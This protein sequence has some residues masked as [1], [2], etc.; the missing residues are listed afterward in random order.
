MR[1]VQTSVEEAQDALLAERAALKAL[2]DTLD[3]APKSEPEPG[4]GPKSEPRKEKGFF[5]NLFRK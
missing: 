2:R 4:P 1:F 5:R 3:P